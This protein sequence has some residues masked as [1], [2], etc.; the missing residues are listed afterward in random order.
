MAGQRLA[1]PYR[2]AYTEIQGDMKFFKETFRFIRHYNSRTRLL[3][4]CCYATKDHHL[5]DCAG[6]P[7]QMTFTD[8]GEQAEWTYSIL[9]NAQWFHENPRATRSPLC[10]IQGWC[11]DTKRDDSMHTV[12]LGTAKRTVSSYPF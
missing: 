5:R 11:I 7:R 8:F 6:V 9:T 3:C 12:S 4:E 2:F 1:G 10:S